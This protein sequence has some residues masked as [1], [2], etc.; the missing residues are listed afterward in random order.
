[1]RDKFYVLGAQDP[2]MREIEQILKSHG[3]PYGYAAVGL[4]RCNAKTAYQAD[5]VITEVFG[6][7][8]VRRVVPPTVDL[9]T[10]ECRL[11]A[12]RPP[13]LLIDHH[14]E[15][16][17]G[18]EAPPTDYMAGASLGQLLRALGL[19]PTTTQRLLAAS[20]HCLTAAYQGECPGV[21]PEE[22]LFLRAS[23]Q[24]KI[25]NKP[26][27]EV[28]DSILLAARLV[29]RAYRKELGESRFLDPTKV[30]AGLPEGSAY[31]GKAVRYR[32]LGPAYELKEMLK[33]ATPAQIRGFMLEHQR[34]GRMVYG[35]PYRGYAGAYFM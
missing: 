8:P 33:G 4:T 7:R 20:D 10:V 3:I 1:M 22:L 13:S 12:S 19:A 23:W 25:A 32:T 14:N 29:E 11:P 6:R 28:I 30:P 27:H 26:L 16:D 17:A 35:N 31:A 18:Y 9:V 21:D 2:E 24:A 5:S 15:G 34:A